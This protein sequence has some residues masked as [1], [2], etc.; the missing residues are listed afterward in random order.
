M[1]VDMEQ[2]DASKKIAGVLA[3]RIRRMMGAT[4]L[5]CW[6][7]VTQRTPVDTGRARYGWYITINAPSDELPPPAPKGYTGVFEGGQPFYSFPGLTD[8]SALA[9]DNYTVTDTLYVTNNVPYVIY[10][11]RGHSKQAP[12]RF[13]EA[14]LAEVRKKAKRF[15]KLTKL[16]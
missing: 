2:P 15:A 3:D 12:A 9:D 7:A 6:R 10:L 4:T 14:A 8:H 16:N 11:N 5:E 13:I 1:N